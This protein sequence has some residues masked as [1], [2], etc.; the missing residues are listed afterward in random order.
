VCR[1]TQIVRA[2]WIKIRAMAEGA[3]MERWERLLTLVNI[4]E[5]LPPPATPTSS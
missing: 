3:T 4:L 5:P 2:I 1:W